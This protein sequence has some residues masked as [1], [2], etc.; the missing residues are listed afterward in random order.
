MEIKVNLTD[1]RPHLSE[2]IG[3]VEFGGKKVII[4]RFG[5][6]TAALVSMDDLKR[7]WAEED[8]ERSGAVNPE[9]GRR[10]GGLLLSPALAAGLARLRGQ[11]K[12][13]GD[14]VKEGR[15]E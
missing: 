7:I 15:V 9:T 12:T 11:G 2:L 13:L 3:E 5:R 1:V 10:R 8:K 14:V 4:E 6:P